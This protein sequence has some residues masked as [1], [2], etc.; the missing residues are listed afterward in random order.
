VSASR[1]RHYWRL[2]QSLTALG[3]DSVAGAP[4]PLDQTVGLD[5]SDVVP[6]PP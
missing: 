5:A 3:A 6:G 4:V 1:L 2:G